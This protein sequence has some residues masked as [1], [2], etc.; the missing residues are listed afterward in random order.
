MGAGP[1][2]RGEGIRTSN[3]AQWL[4]D[5]TSWLVGNF[6]NWTRYGFY[7]LLYVLLLLCA[8]PSQV[9]SK[10]VFSPSQA[11]WE[12]KEQNK[13]LGTMFY[14]WVSVEYRARNN[15]KRQNA[16][17]TEASREQEMEQ[18]VTGRDASP[19]S[20]FI[21]RAILGFPATSGRGMAPF[22]LNV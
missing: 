5:R 6:K 9:F 1:K 21:T 14:R 11:V 10:S 17:E 2:R 16:T 18:A 22:L 4:L 7:L 13:G 15:P 20:F 19:W 12:I 8:H 3:M